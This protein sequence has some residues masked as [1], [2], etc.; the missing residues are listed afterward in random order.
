MADGILDKFKGLFDLSGRTA[1]IAGGAGGIGTAI[2]EGL[3]SRGCRIV[4]TSRD[5]T[6]ARALAE[7]IRGAGGEATGLAL[8][9]DSMDGVKRF[10]EKVYA[11]HGRIDILVN[12]IGGQI[13]AP[14]EEYTEADWDAIFTGSLKT[15]FFLSQAVAKGQIGKNAGKHIHLSSVRSMLG[16][17]RGYV[18]YCS[19]RG[20]M[21]MMIKQ[22]AT[23]WAKHGITVNGI[24]PTFTRTDLVARYLNDPNFYNPL[25]AR[26]PLGRVANP[27]DIAGLAVYLAAPAAD[28]ITGQI[29]FAD[30][31]VTACQ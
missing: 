27:I 31:G 16:I 9:A 28:F 13:E 26:I 6:K 21:N 14:A 2:C 19:S 20:G 17:H 15:A 30:G 24:A 10:V 25:I 3:A 12:C 5:E 1:L 7:T 11:S 4:L 29:V 22:L 18:G 8:R 23:E